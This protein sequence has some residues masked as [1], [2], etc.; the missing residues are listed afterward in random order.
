MCATSQPRSAPSSPNYLNW[1][2]TLNVETLA[3]QTLAF[4]RETLA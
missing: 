1:N 4:R 3:P 2:K